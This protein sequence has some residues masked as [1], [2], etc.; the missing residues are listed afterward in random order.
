MIATEKSRKHGQEIPVQ[1]N[2]SLYPSLSKYAKRH[3]GL[4]REN[5]QQGKQSLNREAS[6]DG[7]TRVAFTDEVKSPP[8]KSRALYVPPP[9]ERDRGNVDQ[10]QDSSWLTNRRASARG[11]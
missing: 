5:S 3:S 8:S 6:S 10:L 4:S 7:Q 11:G 1:S 2:P 9:F